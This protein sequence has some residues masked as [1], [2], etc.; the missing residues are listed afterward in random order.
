[1]NNY[2]SNNVTTELRR[3]LNYYYQVVQKVRETS[4]IRKS[5]NNSVHIY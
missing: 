3:Y 5:E 2:V 4:C 1:M